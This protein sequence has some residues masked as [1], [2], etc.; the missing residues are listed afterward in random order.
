MGYRFTFRGSILGKYY[1]KDFAKSKAR[2]AAVTGWV[3]D[4]I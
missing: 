1:V 4:F 3:D 2:W